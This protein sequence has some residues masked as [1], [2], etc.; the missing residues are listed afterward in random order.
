MSIRSRIH[1][2]AVVVVVSGQLLYSSLCRA[3]TGDPMDW[4]NWRGP[5]QNRVSTETGLIDHWDPDGGKDSNLLWKRKELAGRSTPIVLHGKLYTIVRDQPES[6]L[7]GEKIVCANAATGETLWEH[8]MNVYL[9][10]VPADRAGWS[11]CVAD[12]E[13]GRIYARVYAA[14]SAAWK[15]TPANWSGTIAC[16]K[17]TV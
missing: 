6:A 12:P 2:A 8:R 9:S 13:T 5:Q 3:A 10:D 16:T 4:P 11:S 1:A 7:E 17:S 15:E 14:T